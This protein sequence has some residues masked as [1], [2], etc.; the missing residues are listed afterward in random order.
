MRLDPEVLYPGDCLEENWLKCENC[1]FHAW[2]H[3]I[4]CSVDGL[5][6]PVSGPCRK[7]FPNERP[8]KGGDSRG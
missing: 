3:V 2:G 6:R 7:F 1:R 8:R 5:I 4:L